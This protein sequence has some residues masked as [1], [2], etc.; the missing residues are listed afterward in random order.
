MSLLRFSPLIL[1]IYGWVRVYPG[2]QFKDVEGN[3]REDASVWAHP[4]LDQFSTTKEVIGIK[5]RAPPKLFRTRRLASGEVV[6]VR[7]GAEVTARAMKMQE[8]KLRAL[9]LRRQQVMMGLRR[10]DD[11]TPTANLVHPE[12]EEQASTLSPLGKTAS[13]A[14]HVSDAW[15][16]MPCQE[17][18][19]GG[20]WTT[21]GVRS[22]TVGL[23]SVGPI[24]SPAD[25]IQAMDAHRLRA[26]ISTTLSSEVSETEFQPWVSIASSHDRFKYAGED[27]RP[28][29]TNSPSLL[30]HNV[31]VFGS[32]CQCQEHDS[33]SSASALVAGSTCQMQYLVPP[34]TPTHTSERIISVNSSPPFQPQDATTGAGHLLR[35]SFAPPTFSKL[36]NSSQGHWSHSDQSPGAPSMLVYGPF[37]RESPAYPCE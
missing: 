4:D 11:G 15:A 20:Q 27:S 18:N 7:A 22:P 32:M 21:T 14:F 17:D 29:K 3:I 12:W 34:L 33:S 25:I 6:L 19:Y 8:E 35:P 31:P 37:A 5:R 13:Q 24:P 2:R 28:E 16:M 10:Q 9:A 36:D 30:R 23:A 1:Q 26:S